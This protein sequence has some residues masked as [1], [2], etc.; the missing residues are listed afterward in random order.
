ME[1]LVL[2]ACLNEGLTGRRAV[3]NGR[4]D[5]FLLLS[6]VSNRPLLHA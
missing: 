3:K 5:E 4:K 1:A 6:K 2:E